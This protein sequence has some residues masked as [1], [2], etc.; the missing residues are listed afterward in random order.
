MTTCLMPPCA[1]H[2]TRTWSAVSLATVDGSA[3]RF[4]ATAIA[5][6][7]R[8]RK[9]TTAGTGPAVV[10]RAI[11]RLWLVPSGG[12]LDGRL[13]E[14]RAV[15]VRTRSFERVRRLLRE[16]RPERGVSGFVL[17]HLVGGRDVD[18][19]VPR[20]LVQGADAVRG[21]PDERVDLV[22][23][24][25]HVT[26]A[27]RGA[28]LEHGVDALALVVAAVDPAFERCLKELRGDVLVAGLRE[29]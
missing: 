7:S 6:E 15:D 12:H 22:Q 17:Q 9:R 14:A 25:R 18:G 8:P 28:G 23:L 11:G 5:A 16:V 20:C 1:D 13:L 29:P 2:A 10:A 24:P 21:G 19:L 27:E 4:V 26:L 3:G